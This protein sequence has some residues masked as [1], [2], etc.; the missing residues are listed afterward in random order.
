MATFLLRVWVPDR[1]GALGAVASRIGAVRGDLIGI[2]ILERGAGRA[3]DELVVEL[4]S[5]TLVPLLVSEVSEVDGVDVEDV[6]P[7]LSSVVD[8]RLDA[9]ETAAF[10]VDQ[11]SV[12]ELLE[13]L[14]RRSSRDFQA[15]WAVVLDLEAPS[16]VVE[17]GAAPPA[18]WLQAFVAGSRASAAAAVGGPDD[19]AWAELGAADLVVL[20]GRRGRPF[21]AR[22]RRQLSALARIVDQ[23]WMD[24]VTRS[25]RML[26]PSATP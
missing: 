12:P 17:V 9:L 11:L 8:P 16:P 3:I 20:L 2:D 6:R 19:M 18:A 23:R 14:A 7:A 24:L 26:H 10:L 15:D 4:P 25:A 5:E 21:R 13:A 1:P 22:E